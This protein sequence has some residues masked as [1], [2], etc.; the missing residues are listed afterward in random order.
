MAR[1]ASFY[2][3]PLAGTSLE[4]ALRDARSVTFVD[5]LTDSNVPPATRV[6]AQRWGH[7]YSQVTVPLLWEGRGVGAIV[8][9]RRRTDGFLPKECS[10]LES[11]AD[12]AV[13]ALQNSRLFNETKEALERQTATSEILRVISESPSDV[14]PVLDAVAERARLLCKAEGGRV[15]LVEGDHLRGMTEYGPVFGDEQH[16][17]L[18][19]LRTTSVAGRSVLER[20]SIHLTDVVPLIDSEYPDVRAMQAKYQ[21][22]AMLTMP[23]LREGEALGVI[24]LLRKEARAFTEA[25]IKLLETFADQAVIAIEN[26]RLFNETREALERQTATAAILKVISESPTDIQ[27]V[28]RAIVDTALRLFD[29]AMAVLMRREG[30]GYRLMSLAK[31]GQPAGESVC[32]RG[33]ARCRGQLPVA[34]HARQDDAASAGL[35]GHRV[36]AARA[37]HL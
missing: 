33:A 34:G 15:W 14:Q 24:S 5:A 27:P 30:D 8:V 12:Q 22:H 21:H 35:V 3:R 17:A 4:M 28:F 13:V 32:G 1:E 6:D 18:L 9:A 36:A 16:D 37:A 31:E 29:V 25:E 20:R 7:S 10:L 19:P 11:F 26:V 23:L 2:P